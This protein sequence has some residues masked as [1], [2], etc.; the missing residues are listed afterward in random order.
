[1]GKLIAVLL[2][3]A[4]FSGCGSVVKTEPR[5]DMYTVELHQQGNAVE[6]I[7]SD[8]EYLYDVVEG[9][10]LNKRL[11]L[12]HAGVA[13]DVIDHIGF[14]LEYIRPVTYSGTYDD[15]CGY[16]N[17]LL[18]EGYTLASLDATDSLYD[19]TYENSNGRVRVIYQNKNEIKILFSDF[20]KNIFSPPYI[21]G[22]ERKE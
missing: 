1:M 8:G 7:M 4:L 20:S 5:S 19:A 6:R 16:V 18:E 21:S 2:C 17:R 9:E 11:D 14:E 15:F 22:E 3:A 13:L 12:N 10:Y